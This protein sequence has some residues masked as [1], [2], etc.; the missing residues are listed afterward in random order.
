V[1][2]RERERRGE[3]GAL[4]ALLGEQRD[5]FEERGLIL[6]DPTGS[7][8]FGDQRQEIAAGGLA[9]GDRLSYGVV[10]FQQV[11]RHLMVADQGRDLLPKRERSP[12]PPE[13]SAGMDGASSGVAP[14]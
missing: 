14:R 3:A 2:G 10:V 5:G 12:K 8:G 9:D 6:T 1:I 11:E 13:E 7:V 4:A